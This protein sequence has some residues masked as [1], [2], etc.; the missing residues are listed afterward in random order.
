MLR[1]Y[2]ERILMDEMAFTIKDAERIVT[3]AGFDIVEHL[4]KLAMYGLEFDHAGHLSREIN[5]WCQRIANIKLKTPRR[6]RLTTNEIRRWMYGE[7]LTEQGYLNSLEANKDAYKGGA[8]NIEK[9]CGR[10]SE[11]LQMLNRICDELASGSF[12]RINT[13]KGE[14]TALLK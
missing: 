4:I 14:I 13:I 1:R 10:Y 12:D 3:N 6:S 7:W 11:F 8:A 2:I 5:T 9:M